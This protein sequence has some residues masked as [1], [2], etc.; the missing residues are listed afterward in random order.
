MMALRAEDELTMLVAWS[1]TDDVCSCFVACLESLHLIPA[2]R[3]LRGR[4]I[5]LELYSCLQTLPT[6]VIIL[7]SDAGG[8]LGGRSL[9]LRR[10]SG[11]RNN[12]Y[13]RDGSRAINQ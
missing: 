6:R 9:V 12:I 3:S 4:E 5:F 2:D 8:V 10:V 13:P 1:P 7:H 11:V